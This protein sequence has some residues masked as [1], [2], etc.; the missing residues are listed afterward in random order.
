[1]DS[2]THSTPPLAGQPAGRSAG[3]PA[4]PPVGP[5]D[6]LAA[7]LDR[8]AAEDLDRLSDTALNQDL[9]RLQRQLNSL[10][11]QFLRRLAALDARGAA[12]ADQDQ[13]APSTASWLRQRLRM[14]ANAAHSAV[15][16]ARALFRGPLPESAQALMAG[17]LSA[18]HAQAVVDGTHQLPDQLVAAAE[19][20]LVEA[21]RHLDPPQ[22]RRL[23][24]HLCEVAD[25]DGADRAR[26]YRHERR[27]LWLSPTF[28]RM[29][30]L[31]GLLEPEAGQTVMAAL[32]PL[33]RPAAADD[34]R[35]GGQRTADALTE[36]AR[37]ASEEG[38]L[39]KAGGVQ[40]QL[41]VTVDLDS[42]LGRPGGVGGDMG[43]AGPLDPEACRRLACDGAVTR[44]LVSRQPT[45]QPPS[46]DDQPHPVHDTPATGLG[47][48]PEHDLTDHAGVADHNSSGEEQCLRGRLRAAMTL[49]PPTLGG[50]PCQPLDVGRATR[51][52]QPAQRSALAVR[53]RG[54]VVPGCD[55]PLAWCDAH[56]LWHWVD[57][58]PTDLA[59]LALLC[60]AHHR[61][62]HEGGWQLT[63]G[64]DGRFS[65][66]P[67]PPPHRP[68]R[69]G[70][71]TAA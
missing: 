41:L 3:W 23:V 16:T 64:P 49:L 45:S 58:G 30:A 59:N 32:E 20:V 15:R 11:G 28:D 27:G 35:T 31:N 46:G 65:A 56:H 44:V 7:V 63:R 8:L 55:R 13:P 2:N 67:G 71:P 10:Q 70:R 12:G 21:A 14:S 6:A 47:P 34:T 22:L 40:P 48:A 24:G 51:V 5:P 38:R 4:D 42:L 66:T 26:A 69:R 68:H 62:V 52:V 9:G 37:R 19:P 17:D 43:W 33:A 54:C 60:R 1:M 50:A 39:P 57:G 29:V 36:L 61:A 25:P 18:A 53:D